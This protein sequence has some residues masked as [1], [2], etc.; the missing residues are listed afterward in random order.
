MDIQKPRLRH[1]AKLANGGVLAVAAEA[2]VLI[3]PEWLPLPGDGPFQRGY[4]QV[5]E[6]LKLPKRPTAI[7]TV[8][9]MIG[10]SAMEA[11][12]E[13]GLRIPQD[14][15]VDSID[16]VVESAHT[17]PSL[18]SFRI[19]RTEIGVLAMQKLHR[20]IKG[21]SEIAVKSVVHGDLVVRASCDAT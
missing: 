17:R 20:L 1:R 19:P 14:M 3:P 11:I 4:G 12:K 7:V 2:G 21:E 9:D 16:D 13:A 10:F 15:A 18:T 5:R 8:H 6:L